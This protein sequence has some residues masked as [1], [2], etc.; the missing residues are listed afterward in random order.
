MGSAV[1]STSL[2]ISLL[3]HISRLPYYRW[4]NTVTLFVRTGGITTD[5]LHFQNQHPNM[6]ILIVTFTVFILWLFSNIYSLYRNY[7]L[8]RSS[9]LPIVICITNP[10]NYVWM[11]LNVPLRP[12]LQKVLP[13]S[14]FNNFIQVTT[15]GWE[16]RDKYALHSKVGNVFL[17]VT[18]GEI[19]AWI[20]DPEAVLA[21]LARRKDFVQSPIASKIM[22]ILGPNILSVS[23]FFWGQI[24]TFAF[25]QFSTLVFMK[26]CRVRGDP[27]SFHV[28]YIII[29][30]LWIECFPG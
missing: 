11:V 3:L 25:Y 4:G 24:S 1:V 12:F 28:I 29:S 19:E 7:I 20:A 5:W 17:L 16:F 6:G 22:S 10:S 23:R 9:G 8:A 26:S 27:C 15:Y 18:P 14:F 2:V 13:T 21:V 30:R